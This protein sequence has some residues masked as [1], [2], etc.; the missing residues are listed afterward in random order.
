MKHLNA[1]LIGYKFMGKAHSNAYRQVNHFFGDYA[2]INLKAICGRNKDAVK[3][4]MDT[5]GF[6]SYETD[7]KQLIKRDDI[8]FIDITTVSNNVIKCNNTLTHPMG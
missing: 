7:Y 1:G 4:N 3:K 2:K 5:Y 6:E 8:D